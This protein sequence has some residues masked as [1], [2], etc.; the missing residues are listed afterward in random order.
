MYDCKVMFYYAQITNNVEI[1]VLIQE[2]TCCSASQN[3]QCWITYVAHLHINNPVS[4]PTH[5]HHTGTGSYATKLE[6]MHSKTH[7][8]V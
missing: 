2:D 7:N 5:A 6:N 4:A 1:T 8:P 3:P